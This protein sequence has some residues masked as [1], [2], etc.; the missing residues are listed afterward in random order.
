MVNE[1]IVIKNL[2]KRFE[3]VTA[4]DGIS[5]SVKKASFLGC[6]GRTALG[7]PL[8]LTFSAA[9]LTQQ[10]ARLAWEAMTL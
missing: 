6:L 7:K 3:D 4:V 8:P 2:A 10:V 5:F 1:A 9:S